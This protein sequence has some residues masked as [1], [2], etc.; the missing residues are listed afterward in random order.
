MV[1]TQYNNLNCAS[2][3]ADLF[4]ERN[5]DSVPDS[6]KRRPAAANPN[7]T[8]KKVPNQDAK[9]QQ[10]QKQPLTTMPTMQVVDRNEDEEQAKYV[11]KEKLADYVGCFSQPAMVRLVTSCH[12][13]FFIY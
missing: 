3:P 13:L 9:E 2:Q 1:S 11:P 8:T 7:N 4:E 10:Q 6:F 5:S 12:L